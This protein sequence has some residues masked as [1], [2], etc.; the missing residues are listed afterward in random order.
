MCCTTE[1]G[2][3]REGVTEGQ[4]AALFKKVGLAGTIPL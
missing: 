3:K 1:G 4:I 2:N